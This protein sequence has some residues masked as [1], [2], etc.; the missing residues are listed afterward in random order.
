VFYTLGCVF[1][2]LGCVFCTL[3]CV[4][5]IP[6]CVFC[7][8]GCVFNTLGHHLRKVRINPVKSAFVCQDQKQLQIASCLRPC[9]LH[10]GRQRNM[11]T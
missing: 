5:Y 11:Q 3:G 9:V 6:G 7:T 4:F 1:Y 10:S 8:L 2:T